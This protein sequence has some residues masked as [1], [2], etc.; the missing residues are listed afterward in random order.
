MIKIVAFDIDGTLYSRQQRKILDSTIKALAALK[1]KGI[2]IVVATG[3]T[4][5]LISQGVL[6]KYYDYL[7]SSNGHRLMDSNGNVLF[8]Q[9]FTDA[10]TQQLVD[11]CQQRDLALILKMDDACYLYANHKSFDTVSWGS[12]GVEKFYPDQEDHHLSHPVNCAFIKCSP[13]DKKDFEEICPN[14]EFTATGEST[15]DVYYR[16]LDKAITIEKLL[17]HLGLDWDDCMAVGDGGND[18]EMISRAGIGVV[19]GDGNEELKKLA[20]Y[21]TDSSEHD[22]IYNALKKYQLI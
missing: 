19:M 22:G 8:A 7:V 11:F 3:R 13:Q 12:D 18:M 2:L 9:Y 20:D 5:T 1:E 21:V 10:E 6:S 16:D 4:F 15:Y 14:I 17:Q